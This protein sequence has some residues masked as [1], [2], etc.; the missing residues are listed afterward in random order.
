MRPKIWLAA[1][2][3]L[4]VGS[5]AGCGSKNKGK[6][7]D[8]KWSSRQT[9]VQGNIVP[10]GAL[11]LEFNKDGTMVYRIL[12][13]SYPGKYSLGWGENVTI[14]LDRPLEGQKVHREK[15]SISGDRMT[16]TDPDGTTVEFE[17]V[18]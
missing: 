10:A 3:V 4:V 7:E 13:Q 17:R 6:I 9:T 8:T 15:I 18:K 1:L 12:D 11:K 2:L 14:T 5:A 16:M